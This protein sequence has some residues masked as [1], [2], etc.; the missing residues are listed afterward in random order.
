MG[1]SLSTARVLAPA[2]FVIDFAAQTYG[3]LGTP[4]MKD[5]HDA[6]KSFFSPQPFLIGAFFFPQQIFQLVWLW[7]LHKARPDKSMTATMV[8]FA[9]FYSL[10]NICI[11]CIGVLDLLHN[12]SAAY[13]VDV[14]PSLPVKVL[15]GVGFGL[16]SAVSDWI[17]GGCLVY[18]LL[19]LSVGQSIYGNTGWG[20]LLGIYA[21]G[22][23]AIVGSKNISRPPY[24]V[25]EGYEAL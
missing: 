5:I 2:S 16:M 24:I 19:A 20:K 3:L 12:T 23:A 18:N 9:P 15:T 17:F 22:A 6:N 13:F 1:I 10:G 11:A 21:G 25:G 8:D 7:R 14:Q 4:N